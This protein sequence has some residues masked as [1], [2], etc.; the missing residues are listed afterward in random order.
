MVQLY[1]KFSKKL[2]NSKTSSIISTLSSISINDFRLIKLGLHSILVVLNKLTIT[3]NDI[4]AFINFLTAN[5]LQLSASNGKFKSPSRSNSISS[6][7]SNWRIDGGL[8]SEDDEKY[9]NSCIELQSDIIIE[10]TM[11]LTQLSTTHSK[12]I[13]NHICR[14]LP[15]SKHSFNLTLWDIVL[16]D[17]VNLNAKMSTIRCIECLLNHSKS[18]LHS[19]ADIRQKSLSFTSLSFRVGSMLLE[20]HN[21]IGDTILLEQFKVFRLALLN[22]ASTLISATPYSKMT[23]GVIDKLINNVQVI[24]FDDVNNSVDVKI[25][26]M[27]TIQNSLIVDS[28]MPNYFKNLNDH[29][30][31]QLLYHYKDLNDVRYHLLLIDTLAK[32]WKLNESFINNFKNFFYHLLDFPIQDVK[33]GALN[34]LSYHPH[35][36]DELNED[37]LKSAYSVATYKDEGIVEFMKLVNE[38]VSNNFLKVCYTLF[39]MT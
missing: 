1:S 36:I 30:Y 32:L 35:R 7:H 17:N 27:K 20:L 34:L 6:I 29:I 39:Q 4:S 11:C 15:D 23:T 31:T 37:V 9:P 3:S 24:I 12:Y 8:V 16:S 14:L 28:L 25:E 38:I 5:V 33:Y 21:R 10:C 22:A 2:I 19:S 13:F 26:A 18:Y